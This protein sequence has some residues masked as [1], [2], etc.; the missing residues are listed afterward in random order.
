MKKALNFVFSLCSIIVMLSLCAYAIHDMQSAEGVGFFF[1]LKL[2]APSRVPFDIA[3]DI[4]FFALL[5]AL[6]FIPVMAI[7]EKS[8]HDFS[9]FLITY[10]A[11][12]PSISTAYV[13]GLFRSLDA[14]K[15]YLDTEFL[16]TEFIHHFRIII[17]LI[18]LLCGV[19]Y[20]IKNIKPE[21]TDWIMMMCAFI[22][23]LVSIPF[24]GLYYLASFIASYL[25]VIVLFKSMKTLSGKLWLLHV[26]FFFTA[27][28]RIITVC[29]AYT[30]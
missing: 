13:L 24:P 14:F 20:V 19:N 25:F 7:K 10:I 21:K 12:M 16:T 8:I 2:N 29:Q 15:P 1:C 6:L 9:L 27:V 3:A 22:A 30:L 11:L 18:V 28:Y 17:P 23:I 4:I 5:V 26:V